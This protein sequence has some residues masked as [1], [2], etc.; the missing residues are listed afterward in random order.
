MLATLAPKIV[1]SRSPVP[2]LK[3]DNETPGRTQD[4]TTHALH[5]QASV[6]PG[7]RY[8]RSLQGCR[9]QAMQVSIQ[10]DNLEPAP[11]RLTA[12]VPAPIPRGCVAYFKSHPCR[13][14]DFSIHDP[15]M[16]EDEQ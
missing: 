14:I 12:D 11:P 8:P 13:S 4:L 10:N 3:S 9:S 7:V 15:I 6:S 5:W 2:G 1:V 16:Y